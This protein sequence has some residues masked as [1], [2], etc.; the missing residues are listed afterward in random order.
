MSLSECVRNIQGAGLQ[1]GEDAV[2]IHAEAVRECARHVHA[3]DVACRSEG[4][5][6]VGVIECAHRQGLIG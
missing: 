3:A 2:Q 1:D 6:A 4:E 5:D